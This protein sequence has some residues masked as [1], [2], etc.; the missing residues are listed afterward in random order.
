M[1]ISNEIQKLQTNLANSYEACNDK[2]AT[3]PASQNF[4][5]LAD[6]IGSIPT[7]STLKYIV[8]IEEEIKPVKENLTIVTSLNYIK[9]GALFD[10]IG[11]LSSFSSTNYAESKIGTP[12][13]QN[14]EINVNFTTPTFS[15]TDD[16]PIIA[17]KTETAGDVFIAG[18]TR[19]I[20]S[21]NNT[22][23]QFGTTTLDSNKNYSF[24]LV[25][26]DSSTSMYLKEGLP[27]DNI[28]DYTL[29]YSG[30][31]NYF[32]SVVIL[33]GKYGSSQWYTGS[34]NMN[35]C[36]IKSGDTLVWEGITK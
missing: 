10:N 29:E 22:T 31:N 20:S 28:S 4:D 36:N 2:G 16:L 18:G 30:Y 34:I 25:R 3:M 35:Y 19:K 21:W 5:N 27:S 8:G 12:T 6:C 15:G 14:Y 32:D 23:A 33:F 9:Y 7:G 13:S 24:K 11:V 26:G 17:K 1:S